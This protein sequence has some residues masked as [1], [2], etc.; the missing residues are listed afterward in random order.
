MY[1]NFF[2]KM[3]MNNDEEINYSKKIFPTFSTL[4]NEMGKL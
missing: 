1:V 4:H 3:W 2:I